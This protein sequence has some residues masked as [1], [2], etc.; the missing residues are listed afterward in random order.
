MNHEFR[1]YMHDGPHAFSF[2]L[3][4]KLSDA[5]MDDVI[6]WLISLGRQQ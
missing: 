3:A 5:Q 1:Y 2:E 4:G 6:A